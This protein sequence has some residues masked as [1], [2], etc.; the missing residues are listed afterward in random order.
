MKTF[1][2]FLLKKVSCITDR[3][4]FETNQIINTPIKITIPVNII[5]K[6]IPSRINCYS[7][8]SKY[9]YYKKYVERGVYQG[10]PHR[11]V[12]TYFYEDSGRDN[13]GGITYSE[14]P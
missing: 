6:F 2:L 3:T 10:A 14:P 9:I 11:R 12:V 4:I 7:W 13:I 5:A 1:P 8:Y